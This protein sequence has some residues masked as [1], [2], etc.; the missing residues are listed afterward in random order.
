[1]AQSAALFPLYRRRVFFRQLD[2]FAPDPFAQCASN[3]GWFMGRELL[4]HLHAWTHSGR[5]AHTPLW[6]G[7][8]VT[9][10]ISGSVRWFHV[11]VVESFPA[12]EYYRRFDH[13]FCDCADFP[14]SG[15]RNTVKGW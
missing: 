3:S 11:A 5:V 6:N 15:L 9:G 12:G 14:R 13:R 8:L 7:E 10:G 2:V 4:G 1:M